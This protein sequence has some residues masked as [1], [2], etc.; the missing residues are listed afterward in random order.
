MARTVDITNKFYSHAKT[1]D[2]TKYVSGTSNIVASH[3]CW[4]TD[5]WTDHTGHHV[6]AFLSKEG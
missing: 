2:S 1:N 6:G 4:A 3:I 5:I